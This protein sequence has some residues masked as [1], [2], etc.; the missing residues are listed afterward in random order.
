MKIWLSE[1][2]NDVDLAADD[3][4][5]EPAFA[6]DA[7]A[8]EAVGEIGR[9]QPQIRQRLVLREQDVRVADLDL[10]ARLRDVGAL[11]ERAADGRVHVGRRADR[12]HDIGGLEPRGPEVGPLRIE[13]ARAQDVFGEE[14]RR[15]RD[16]Q[17]LAALR[18]F[19]PRRDEVQRRRLPDV[20]ARAVGAFELERQIER[21]LLHV[22]RRP[23]RDEQPVRV[24]HVGRRCGRSAPAAGGPRCPGCAPRCRA[25]RAPDRS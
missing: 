13:D 11:A 17:V 18:D 3:R 12:R 7:R 2:P 24:L 20:H 16:D 4:A 23:R 9:L 6:D 5:G 14:R 21:A 15:A 19:R 25:A 10:L 22:D 1:E 8:G